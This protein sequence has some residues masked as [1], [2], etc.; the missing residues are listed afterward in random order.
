MPRTTAEKLDQIRRQ[1][2]RKVEDLKW[3]TTIEESGDKYADHDHDTG[4]AQTEPVENWRLP[5]NH[6][7]PYFERIKGYLSLLNREQVDPRHVEAYMRL[8]HPTLDGLSA[9]AFK[10]EVKVS[11]QCIDASTPEG[12][13]AAAQSFGL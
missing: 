11:I 7:S 5:P 6:K 10:K 12:N 4:V 2:A 13:E 1:E 9:L 3:L 8:E